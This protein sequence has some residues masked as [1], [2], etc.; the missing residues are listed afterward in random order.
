VLIVIT[1]WMGL[2]P[3]SPW[4]RKLLFGQ[5]LLVNWHQIS[6]LNFQQYWCENLRSV[7]I[8]IRHPFQEYY[9]QLV[10]KLVGRRLHYCMVL[11]FHAVCVD[12]SYLRR[13]RA[14]V[15]CMLSPL[16]ADVKYV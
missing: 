15:F 16:D 3:P 6:G 13:V 2:V 7:N 4:S 1:F 14:E 8:D 11:L 5:Q 10:Y 12:L 9:Q